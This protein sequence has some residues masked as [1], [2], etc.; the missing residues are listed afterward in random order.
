MLSAIRG[1]IRL[2]LSAGLNEKGGVKMLTYYVISIMIK[3]MWGLTL[4][5]LKLTVI[6]LDISLNFIFGFITGFVT[7][8]ITEYRKAKA[9]RQKA[10][11]DKQKINVPQVVANIETH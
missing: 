2:I 7:A 5:G 6:V 3:I 8:F 11:E 9:A 4:A 1:I 10:V